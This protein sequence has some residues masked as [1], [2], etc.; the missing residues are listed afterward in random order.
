[1]FKDILDLIP[2]QT[3]DP[4]WTYSQKLNAI[5]NGGL[6]TAGVC[7][8]HRSWVDGECLPGVC[9]VQ[10]HNIAFDVSGLPCPD[11]SCAGKKLY[12]AGPTS[13]VYITHGK[14]ATVQR[15]PLLLIECTKDCI[16]KLFILGG[17][18][19]GRVI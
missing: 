1:M 15:I 19:S 11:M 18:D 16:D 17:F 10:K 14:W 6:A 7:E 8:N 12:R 3:S 4:T 13:A 9:S 2:H 5:F